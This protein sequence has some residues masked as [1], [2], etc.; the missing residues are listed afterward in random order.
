MQHG[1]IQ[2]SGD[3]GP[4]GLITATMQRVKED[5]AGRGGV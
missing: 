3:V 5:D 1:L 2:I 4:G